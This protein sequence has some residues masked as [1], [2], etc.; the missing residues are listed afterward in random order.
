MEQGGKS[1]SQYQLNPLLTGSCSGILLPLDSKGY[2]HK[3]QR[4]ALPPL[5]RQQAS[6]VTAERHRH[7]RPPSVQPP[8]TYPHLNRGATQGS[9][10][11]P[12]VQRPPTCSC[13]GC[14]SHILTAAPTALWRPLPPA[15]TTQAP[16]PH[17][18]NISTAWDC[19]SPCT[20]LTSSAATP[21]GPRTRI[22][23][24]SA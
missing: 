11:L 24:P 3:S 17:H 5:Y 19:L 14:L 9:Q 8:S 2:Q 10:G 7:H 16:A 6:S 20:A 15:C 21:S 1:S 12:G 22:P 23:S 18:T 4:V 13:P